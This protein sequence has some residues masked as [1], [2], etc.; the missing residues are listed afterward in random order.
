MKEFVP[1]FEKKHRKMKLQIEKDN[2]ERKQKTIRDINHLFKS[3][4]KEMLY[5]RLEKCKKESTI[6]M[7]KWSTLGKGERTQRRATI[8][9]R[10]DANAKEMMLI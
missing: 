7:E 8:S 5:N 2:L 6:L 9:N 4:T 10:T 1:K 3:Y